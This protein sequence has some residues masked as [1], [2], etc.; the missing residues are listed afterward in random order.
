MSTEIEHWR[1]ADEKRKALADA[2]ASEPVRDAI[3]TMKL[4]YV[5]G[6]AVFTAPPG[7]TGSEAVLYK[8]GYLEGAQAA[9]ANLISLPF[10]TP[11]QSSPSTPTE[12]QPV[13]WGEPSKA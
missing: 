2:L 10:K 13:F 7:L 6:S 4:Y 9:L 12:G 11:R 8:Q 5:P 1:G 3:L